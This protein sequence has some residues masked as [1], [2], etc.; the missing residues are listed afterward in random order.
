MGPK[1]WLPP[2]CLLLVHDYSGPHDA[3]L[4]KE[5]LETPD[6]LWREAGRRIAGRTPLRRKESTW[7][8]W[9]E[10]RL[11]PRVCRGCG[12]LARTP[13]QQHPVLRE[14]RTCRRC[15]LDPGG[16][17][18][19]VSGASAA[20]E[21][22]LERGGFQ[23]EDFYLETEVVAAAAA[24]RGWEWAALVSGRRSRRED[25]R[26]LGWLRQEAREERR[27]RAAD[28]R[29]SL[30]WQELG[31]DAPRVLWECRAFDLVVGDHLSADRLCPRRGLRAVARAYGAAHEAYRKTDHLCRRHVGES[32][33]T[34]IPPEAL[35]E[36]LLMRA[37]D[38]NVNLLCASCGARLPP[39]DGLSPETCD[40]C[41]RAAPLF[42][43]RSRALI[44]ALAA[45]TRSH[46]PPLSL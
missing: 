12:G 43:L 15:L 35:R 41:R 30:L 1:W 34:Q 24:A 14:V 9:F 29:R 16:E 32:L 23:Q 33:R 27:L 26:R 44:K 17:Y 7:E 2:E 46:L 40:R 42:R 3:F 22:M 31:Q 13:L 36:A 37:A 4:S 6:A 28:E 18:A 5:A 10:R 21:F 20:R 19:V 45:T 11:L 25:A 8:R 38:V 39:Q